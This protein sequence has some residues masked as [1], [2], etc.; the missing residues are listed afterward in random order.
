MMRR[1]VPPSFIQA[2]IVTDAGARA[3]RRLGSFPL[4]WIIAVPNARLEKELSS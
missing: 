4:F 1:N 2:N 3:A